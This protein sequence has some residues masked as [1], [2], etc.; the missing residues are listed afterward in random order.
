[1]RSCNGPGS[2]VWQT[3]QQ[4][5]DDNVEVYVSFVYFI[6]FNSRFSY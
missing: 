6:S 1:M 2:V 3:K 5:R 4:S